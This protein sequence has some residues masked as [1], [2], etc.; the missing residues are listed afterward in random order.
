MTLR[1][2]AVPHPDPRGE[3]YA[4]AY[5]VEPV[6]DDSRRFRHEH[7]GMVNDGSESGMTSSAVRPL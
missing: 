5:G 7:Q 6:Y 1:G 3:A 4:S 2:D